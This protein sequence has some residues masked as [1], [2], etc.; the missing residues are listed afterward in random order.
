[1]FLIFPD[2]FVYR[3][4]FPALDRSSDEVIVPVDAPFVLFE[5]METTRI[6]H[7]DVP[8]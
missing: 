6:E 3:P 2:F 1:M 8:T 4:L 7:I 5:D